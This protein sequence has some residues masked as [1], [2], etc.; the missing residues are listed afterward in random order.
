[1]PRVRRLSVPRRTVFENRGSTKRGTVMKVNALL[2]VNV[3][4]L[5]AEDEVSVLV[6]VQAPAAPVDA[7]RTPATLQVVL[8]RSGSMTG[9]P[10]AGAQRAL[11]E[12]VRKL[13]P[14]DNFGLVTFDDSAQVVVPSGPL[15]D[16]ARVIELIRS[17]VP[18]G[19]TD[20]SAGYLRGLR[21]VRRAAGPTGG[22]VLVISDGH[23]NAGLADPSEFASLAAKAYHDKVVTST[24]GY[25]RGYDETLLSEIARA[26]SGN[27]VLPTTRTPRVQRSPVRLRGCSTGW[28]RR[29]H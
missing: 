1:M 2:D 26:G 5:E 3:V 16:K 24:L 11:V 9:A 29:C 12:L 18:G 22:T 21:E 27:H 6:E 23:V 25:G 4:A 14:S 17:V 13:E 10:L 7:A 19:T 8:D 15:S 28:R 20:L